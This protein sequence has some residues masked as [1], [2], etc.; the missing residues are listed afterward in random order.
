MSAPIGVFDSGVGGLT[1][2]RT[3]AKKLPK[4]SFIYLGDTARLPY[5]TKSP[6]TIRAYSEQVMNY[7][8][9]LGVKAIVIACNSASS[10]VF[11]TEWRAIPVYNVIEPGARAA[12][13]ATKNKRVGVLGTRA[14]IESGVYTRAVRSIDSV[15]SIF[16]QA[17][18]LFVPLAEEGWS[19]DPITK[20]VAE[21]YL[22]PILQHD[23]DTLILGCTHYPLLKATIQNV[24]GKAVVLVESGEV[25]ARAL[26]KDIQSGRITKS[27][28]D[29]GSIRVLKTD[30]SAHA[31]ALSRA[32]LADFQISAIEKV[33]LV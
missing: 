26:L 2:L 25:L 10:Q 14:T 21:R 33:D 23:I 24:C 17:C 9:K 28:A 22:Q 30:L 4:E 15:V 13:V 18:P 19:E 3:L 32:I 29:H 12:V 5:G 1:V 31:E 7:L 6:A 27:A 20:V 11:E 8:V 16:S